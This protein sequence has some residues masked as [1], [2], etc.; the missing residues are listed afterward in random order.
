M[1]LF[2]LLEGYMETISPM[3]VQECEGEVDNLYL[4]VNSEMSAV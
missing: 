1:E 2:F 4:V 3:E